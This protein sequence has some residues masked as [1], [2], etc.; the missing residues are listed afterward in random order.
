[1]QLP[2]EADFP[3]VR[4][5]LNEWD[6]GAAVVAGGFWSPECALAWAGANA[7]EPVIMPMHQ[8]KGCRRGGSIRF[9]R[10]IAAGIVA[11]GS[12]ADI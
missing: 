3:I 1:M 8:L 11:F 10:E 2:D 9:H 5:I 4:E 6:R 12:K 7:S